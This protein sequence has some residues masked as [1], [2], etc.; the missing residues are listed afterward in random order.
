MLLNLPATDRSSR[1]V[2][3]RAVLTTPVGSENPLNEKEVL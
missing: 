3:R 1:S 2:E